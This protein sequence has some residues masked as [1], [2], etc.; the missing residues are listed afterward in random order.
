LSEFEKLRIVTAYEFLKHIRRR[1]L[2]V[3]LGLT[4]VAELAVLILI[5]ALMEGYPDNVMVMAAMLTI[6]PTLA[7]IGAVFF[8][9]DA[10]AGEFESKTGLIL[11]TN[12]V[13]RITL[14]TGKYL[15][16]CA[17]VILLI[18]F[19]YAITSIALLAI[20][21][22]IP[23]ETA[24]SFGLCLLYA[25]SVLSV[26]FFFSSVSKGA[27]G[28]TVITLVFIMVISGI[29]ESVLMLAG[30]PYWFILSSAGDSVFTVYGGYERLLGGIMPQGGMGMMPFEIKTPD[31]GLCA[32]AMVI[33]LVVGF[34][35]SLWISQRR[36][37]A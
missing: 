3:I 26:T 35:L 23:I 25:G 14:V 27:M 34:V 33:Y 7:T 11:F 24:K 16:G 4:F 21:G 19:G 17:A 20:Y 2:Y 13:K 37:L 1:R 18:I 8:A 10:I 30:K 29:I 32:L 6:G 22:S 12:P 15:A 31:I 9:G 28:A 36:Q 5:P